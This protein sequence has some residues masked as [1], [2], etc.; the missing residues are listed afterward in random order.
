[1]RRAVPQYRPAPDLDSRRRIHLPF[2]AGQV[3]TPALN[4]SIFSIYCL[5]HETLS[6]R[7]KTPQ[8]GFHA[9]RSCFYNIL[10]IN[11]LKKPRAILPRVS[12]NMQQ[13][14]FCPQC[15]LP[16]SRK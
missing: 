3:V 11:A 4:R 13:N 7:F 6:I 10:V 8:S 16:T 2:V 5:V 1:L 9:M 12:C 15:N 14:P